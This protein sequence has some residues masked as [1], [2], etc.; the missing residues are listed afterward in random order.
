MQFIGI[1]RI[2]NDDQICATSGKSSLTGHSGSRRVRRRLPQWATLVTRGRHPLIS[3]PV[4]FSLP[5]LSCMMRSPK[6]WRDV[7]RRREFI[8][9]VAD[10]L[11]M[12]LNGELPKYKRKWEEKYV[13]EIRTSSTR[14][15]PVRWICPCDDSQ[16][17]SQLCPF[18]NLLGGLG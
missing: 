18:S 10:L 6:P 2:V 9:A 8:Y 4:P 16:S 13:D 11:A 14:D 12:F 15:Y 5:I 1:Q 3:P 17:L 7:T